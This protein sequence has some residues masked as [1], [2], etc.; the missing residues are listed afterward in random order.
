MFS[1]TLAVRLRAP[2]A[3]PELVFDDLPAVTG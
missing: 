1:Q 3:D 2:L